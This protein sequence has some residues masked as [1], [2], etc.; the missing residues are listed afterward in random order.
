MKLPSLALPLLVALATLPWVKT[1]GQAPTFGATDAVVGRIAGGE[2]TPMNQKLTPTGT[3]VELPGMRPN[4]LAL[5]PDGRLLVTSGLQPELVVVDPGSGAIVERVPFPP[6]VHPHST[7][8]TE[9]GYLNPRYTD[10]LSFTGI[11]FSP[12]GRRIYLSNVNGDVKVFAVD[13]GG[14][15]RALES[16]ELPPANAPQRQA[17]IPA[18]LAVSPDG[19]RLYVALNLSNRLAELDTVTGRVLR[20]WNTG[21]APYDVALAGGRAFVSNWGGPRPGPG[22]LTGNAGRG[23][24]VRVDRRLIANAGSVTAIA[25]HGGGQVDIPT[26]LHCSALALSP[27]GRTLVAANT[28]SDTL[29]VIDTR[30]ERVT[31]TL[32]AR[33]NAADLFGAQPDALAFD[34]SGR[35]LYVCNGTQNAVAVFSLRDAKRLGLIPV[36]WFPCA[37]AYDAG[38]RELCVANIKEIDPNKV[39]PPYWARRAGAA[40]GFNTL[41]YYGS[42]SLVPVPSERRLGA[43]TQAALDDLRYPL[44]AEAA[45]PA[46]PGE[47]PRPVPERVG[48]PS[49][50][51]HV[52]YIIKENRSYDQVLGDVTEGDGDPDLCTFGARVTPNEHQLVKD[53]VLLDNT[54]CCSILSADGHQWTDSAMAN[55]YVE[56]SFAGWPRSYAADALALSSAGFIWDDALRHGKTV[57]D[58]GEFSNG[59]ARWR[60]PA[61]HGTPT[62]LDCYRSFVGHTGAV[63]YSDVSGGNSDVSKTAATVRYMLPNAVGWN[64]GIPDVYRAAQ[65]IQDLQ[66]YEAR[67]GLPSLLIVWLPDDHTSATRPGFPTPEAYEADNDL[68]MGRV[69][70]ALSHSRFW[71]DTCLFAIEDDPQNG[72][73]HV[74]AYRTTAYVVSAYT[75][76][77]AVVHTQYNQT[78]LL[79]TIELMLGLPPMNQMDATATPMFDCFTPTPDFAPYDAV[80]E[81]VPLDQMNPPARRIPN[82]T[83]RRDAEI[84][85][86]LP[87]AQ[88]DQCPE[89]LFNRILWHDLKGPDTPYPAAGLA[90]AADD[91]D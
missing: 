3:Q 23:M 12:D 20:L 72:W 26:G 57:G 43:L 4:A 5:S 84:S 37:V 76:R 52:I 53:F 90:S 31:E 56:R 33:E 34:P 68:A 1:R 67:G 16:F 42:L 18:G 9:Q 32:S 39:R 8:R 91:D 55:D 2:E 86:R 46:R 66:G 19:R 71:K 41:N 63:V 11:V 50:F 30:S 6:S 28:G 73:D 10:K 62:W 45:L 88:E 61:R 27:D 15:V 14:S 38:R 83:L 60:D 44:M 36:G 7:G 59:V 21:V 25:L 24:R 22:S 64:L 81:T 47:P 77:G 69:V 80:P 87:F 78:S 13:A 17:E 89:D 65:F 35:R 82:R 85:A 51:R 79:R 40:L 54:Y 75:R 70:Q 49:V 48:E 74:S 29:S 58:F